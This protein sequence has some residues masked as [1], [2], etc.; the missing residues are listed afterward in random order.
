MTFVAFTSEEVATGPLSNYYPVLG[1]IGVVIR[2]T[3]EDEYKVQFSPDC[4]E[5]EDEHKTA[6]DCALYMSREEIEDVDYF[7]AHVMNSQ[8]LFLSMLK[9]CL[10]EEESEELEEESECDLDCGNCHCKEHENEEENKTVELTI[11]ESEDLDVYKMLLPKFKKNGYVTKTNGIDSGLDVVRMV[12]LAYKSGYTRA[13]KGRPF[14]IETKL[15]E[16]RW[17]DMVPSDVYNTNLEVMYANAV[18][19]DRHPEGPFDDGN[20][21]FPRPGAIGKMSRP[22]FEEDDSDKDIWI[23]FPGTTYENTCYGKLF[24][25]FLVRNVYDD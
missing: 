20:G 6:E 4:F 3:D 21:Y 15:T 13:E 22:N 16:S 14:K 9:D 19:E 10:D 17:R 8:K 24:D 23:Q 7:A 5:N 25:C 18:N 1:S 2:Q 12:A 11:E